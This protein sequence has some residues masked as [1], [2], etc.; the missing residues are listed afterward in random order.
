[1]QIVLRRNEMLPLFV[2]DKS[3]QATLYVKTEISLTDKKGQ[4]EFVNKLSILFHSFNCYFANYYDFVFI[5]TK[6]VP[7]DGMFVNYSD[8]QAHSWALRGGKNGLQLK[9]FEMSYE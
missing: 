8:G 4:Q 6:S 9:M 7:A 3:L 5:S 1:M 2:V